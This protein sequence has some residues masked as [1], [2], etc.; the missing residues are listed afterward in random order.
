MNFKDELKN[1]VN[2]I[3]IL[4]NEYMPKEEGY[5]KTIFEAM[6]Y[7]LSA[8][9]KRL[10]PILTLEACKLVGGNEKDA[11]PFA[12]AIEMIHTY[13]LIHDD[14]PALD[15]DDLRRGRKTNHKVYG[16]AMAIL[17]G[18]GLLN[19]AYEIMLKESI[20]KDDSNKYL[21]A[22]N[23]I[24]KASGIYGMIGGQV[25]DIESEG[26][27]I[28]K[29]K[30][31]F[32]HMNKTAAIIIGCMRAGAII[33]GA[34]ENQLENITKYAKNI[35]LSFQIVDDILDVVGDEAKLGKKVGS[36][37]DNE[38]S[39]YPSLIGLDKS[40]EIAKNLI[41]EAKLSISNIDKDREF[42]NSLADYIVDREY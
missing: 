38:K 9:G 17:A 30:L 14:L 21:K 8:G 10:R 3:E 6:N 31:D 24:A 12:A 35:G 29:D 15:N 20:G 41:E 34:S 1:R 13:S 33:G 28:D 11:I 25:V 27:S 42:L 19:Y 7:S 2:N 4:L 5:Q 36:D 16:E 18:D 32:I 37:I 22:I 23:E 26:K 39:T 40:K